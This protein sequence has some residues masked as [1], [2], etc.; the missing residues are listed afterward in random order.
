MIILALDGSSTFNAPT[1]SFCFQ[2]HSRISYDALLYMN[3][4]FLYTNLQIH[5]KLPIFQGWCE[6]DQPPEH[7]RREKRLLANE[8]LVLETLFLCLWPSH[9][10]LALEMAVAKASVSKRF[11]WLGF[12]WHEC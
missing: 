4:S 6:R 9:V 8:L 7:D 2:L 12:L 5:P 1:K 3:E 10:I 11:C